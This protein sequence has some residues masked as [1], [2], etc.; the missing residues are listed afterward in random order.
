MESQGKIIASQSAPYALA[1]T[2]NHIVA[3]GCDKKITVYEKDGKILRVFDYSKEDEKS[4]NVACGSPS[5]Q[6]VALGSYD[7]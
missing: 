7:R 6:A 3:A 2:L 5:G 1:W 4:F